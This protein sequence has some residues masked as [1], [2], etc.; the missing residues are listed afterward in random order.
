MKTL[1]LAGIF[2][3]MVFNCSAQRNYRAG[4]T[5]VP[6][7]ASAVGYTTHTFGADSNFST[8]TVDMGLTYTSGFQW[9][10]YNFFGSSP[11]SAITLNLDGSAIITAS[12]GLVSAGKVSGSPY[13]KGT[14][15]GCGG[16]LTA[17]Y[18]FDPNFQFAAGQTH[19]F[20]A[21]WVMSSEYLTE[22]GI[23]ADQWVGQATGYQHFAELDMFEWDLPYPYTYG[24][25]MHDW[26]GIPGTTCTGW[27]LFNYGGNAANPKKTDYTLY[28]R[29]AALWVPATSSTDG[30][31][32][33]F[34]D[35]VLMGTLSWAQFTGQAPPPS[36]STP[37]RFGVIDQQHM[38]LIL[39]G[40][41]SPMTVRS[42]D[43]WQGAG[44]CNLT[45]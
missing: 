42:V 36:S 25:A 10:M 28:H 32:K 44:A 31:V 39:S 19:S 3:S 33:W 14:V 11:S 43:V 9:Y 8:S 12:N 30:Y 15:F 6:A 37:W 45:N 5:A 35:D 38:V 24:I 17:E 34:F 27:C 22:S 1:F 29:Y 13:F 23:L 2:L 40:G 20:P 7:A 41:N 4:G 16:Y 26:W 18:A 21:W